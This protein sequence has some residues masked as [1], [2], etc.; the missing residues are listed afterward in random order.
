MNQAAVL[1]F[2]ITG[3][4]TDFFIL[5]VSPHGSKSLDVKLLGTEGEAV[6]VTKR[7]SHIWLTDLWFRAAI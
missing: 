3:R 1:R 2:P 5:E 6:F 4:E 7:R